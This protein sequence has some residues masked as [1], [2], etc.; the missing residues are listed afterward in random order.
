MEWRSIKQLVFSPASL[1]CTSPSLPSPPSSASPPAIVRRNDEAIVDAAF[2]GDLAEVRRLYEDGVS[3]DSTDD[4]GWTALMS[5][6]YQGHSSIV[7]YLINNGA[8]L[9]I[10]SN[11]GDTA[12]MWA[13]NYG[14]EKVLKQLIA[15]GAD[16]NVRNNNGY[17][18][19]MVAVMNDHRSC[20]AQLLMER[21][22]DT[23]VDNWDET[24]FQ[25]AVR[26]NRPNGVEDAWEGMKAR[27][28]DTQVKM[29]LRCAL[30]ARTAPAVEEPT[31]LLHNFFPKLS[32]SMTSDIM[33]QVVSH[34]SGWDPSKSFD[35]DMDPRWID[36]R[37]DVYASFATGV[38]RAFSSL[39]EGPE[40]K[41]KPIDF[42]MSFVNAGLSE[43]WSRE[44]AIAMMKVLVKDRRHE[45]GHELDEVVNPLD[46]TL[47]SLEYDGERDLVSLHCLDN[48]EFL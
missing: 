6:S 7:D 21:A 4:F 9:D 29:A 45:Y 44:R 23:I 47:S 30:A 27:V 18:A 15:A 48:G 34:W 41:N 40:R 5:A 17:T 39:P 13:A 32:K 37:S 36:R 46:L 33:L 16:L 25:I 42:F 8:A 35:A 3:L 43:P 14:R 24:A 26:L 1:S 10:G 20:V 11:R 38:V 22:D 31:T 19:L 12:L 28:S 2:S